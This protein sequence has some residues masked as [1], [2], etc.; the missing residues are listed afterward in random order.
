MQLAFDFPV[1]PR[2]R[3]DNFVVCSGNETA[4]AFA[5]RLLAP[6]GGENLLY[7][8]GAGGS[9]KTHLLTAI[10]RE[11]TSGAE[12]LIP[13]I[14]AGK[15]PTDNFTETFAK[16][17][18]LPALLL[19]DLHQLS[20]DRSLTT[21]LW[22]LFNDFYSSGRKI[23]ATASLPPKELAVLDEHL[24]SRFMWGLVARMDVSDDRS[25]QAILK[26][27]AEDR[28]IILPDDVIEHLL[29]HLPRDITALAAGLDRLTRNAF[30][31]QRKIS[32]K[33]ARETF[34][35]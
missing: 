3:L 28:Q 12:E 19:D 6:V 25:R 17:R 33:L 23:V 9:G 18:R 14:P 11:L 20:A 1:E 29:A 27:L 24:Q 7:L 31:T 22:Q 15:L 34:A 35:D 13:V 26:K 32:L 16:L 2:Y 4:Y 30:A 8:H 10:G 5:T 21:A